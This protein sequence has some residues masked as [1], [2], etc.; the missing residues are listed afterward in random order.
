MGAGRKTQ[1]F[2]M[3]PNPDLAPYSVQA[4]Q[5]RSNHLGGVIFGCKSS[6]M[7]ECLSKQLFGL[8]GP[9]FSYVKNISPG[10]PLFLFNYNDRSL[11]GIYEAASHGQMNI[12]PY[13]WTTDGS[14][15]TQFP[16]Q[17][18]IRVRLQCK[19][20][21]ESHCAIAPGTSV[22]QKIPKR[23]TDPP[24]QPS[25]KTTV[26]AQWLKPLT[27]G[28]KTLVGNYNPFEAV[29]DVKDAEQDEQHLI[30]AKLKELSLQCD[31]NSEYQNV[32]LSID[33]KDS[34]IVNAT[35]VAVNWNPPE[36]L[37]LVDMRV[38]R[39]HSWSE[40]K[41]G[42]SPCSLSALSPR[43][44]SDQSQIDKLVQEVEELKAF[45]NEQTKKIGYLEYKLEQ[46][47]SEIKQLKDGMKLESESAPSLAHI[48]EKAGR[49]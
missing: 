12:D 25:R 45:K 23:K 24:T 44:L 20:L 22:P 9:D 40:K 28:A 18:Q 16:A 34:A 47:Q 48:D 4:R 26:E 13:G 15:R 42:G 17:V 21:L 1:T 39:S 37:G 5:L 33:V 32:P 14:V 46:A 7:M 38:E 35:P 11:H 10:L 2:I 29:L 36:P 27:S 30:C 8:P 31:H 41:S 49:V 3:P 19:P 43:S 6:T